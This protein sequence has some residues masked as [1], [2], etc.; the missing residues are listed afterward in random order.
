MEV[1][2]VLI[3]LSWAMTAQTQ[4]TETGCTIGSRRLLKSVSRQDR[5]HSTQNPHL[6]FRPRD[7]FEIADLRTKANQQPFPMA[8]GDLVVGNQ[9]MRAE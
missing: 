8:A 7:H 5:Q 4:H 9:G 3:G 1:E 2:I 6:R